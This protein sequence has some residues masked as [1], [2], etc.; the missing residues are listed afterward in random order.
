MAR[1]LPG[2]DP[3]AEALAAG[4]TP[5]PAMVAASDDTGRLSVGAAVACRALIAAGLVTLVYWGSQT[6]QVNLTPMPH[7]AEVLEQ[8]AREMVA[9][10]GYAQP[11]RDTYRQFEGADVRT[12]SAAGPRTSPSLS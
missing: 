3:L 10:F 9:G 11:L 4:E 6:V 12:A 2:G 8:K 5:S 1:A 7:S